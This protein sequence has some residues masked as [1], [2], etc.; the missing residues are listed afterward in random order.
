MIN[1][2]LGILCFN[3]ILVL[4]KFLGIKKIDNL[5]ALIFNYL[6]AGLY[7]IWYSWEI[8]TWD[9]L[10]Y[11]DFSPYGF[12]I[13]F[14]F[15]TSFLLL[16]I[17]AQKIGMGISTT[18][19]KMSVILPIIAAI[20]LFNESVTVQKIIGISLAL[21]A[22]YFVTKTKNNQANINIKNT[23]LLL[24]IFIGQ[25]VADIFFNL[26]QTLYVNE[27]QTGLF[28][29]CIFLSASAIGVIMLFYK[30]LKKQTRFNAKAI[31]WGFLIGTF[32]FGTLYF[33]FQAL[34]SEI[35]ESSKIYPIFNIAIV[36]IA[37]LV[38][39]FGFK[40]KLNMKNWLGI[41]FAVIS[42]VLL[43]FQL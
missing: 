11:A 6:F 4:F 35:L 28:F 41:A 19:N 21:L 37:A 24:L 8:F 15:I 25:G 33:F 10:V 23:L 27:A 32:N 13:G 39:Y 5:Q 43:S 26:A 12:G 34:E 36:L 1:I 18:A 30:L 2:I 7:G 3:V 31:F 22:V 17:A 38:G 16:A 14:F 9:N 40:E 42:I 20:V 29:T